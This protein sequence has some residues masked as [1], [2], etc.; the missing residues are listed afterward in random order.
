MKQLFFLMLLIGIGSTAYAQ[1]AES[2]IELTDKYTTD[3]LHLKYDYNLMT[4]DGVLYA[5]NIYERTPSVLIRYP[6]GKN[7]SSFSIPDGVTRICPNAFEGVKLESLYIPNTV[8]YIAYDAFSNAQI[9]R[10]ESD[11]NQSAAV[12]SATFDAEAEAEAI[13]DAAG[14]PQETL[15]DPDKVYIIHLKNG[16]TLKVKPSK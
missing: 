1:S 12:K 8:R 10:F 15:S 13:Y 16:Q 7:Q 9:G 6:S 3:H 11:N 5:A 14:I 2:T 4:I